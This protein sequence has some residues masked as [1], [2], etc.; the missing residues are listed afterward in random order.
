MLAMEKE[1]II[2]ASALFDEEKLLPTYKIKTGMPGKSYGID[3]ASRLGMN[4]KIIQFAKEY[5]SHRQEKDIDTAINKLEKQILLNEKLTA[6]LESKKRALES[7]EIESNRI[8]NNIDKIKE[9]ALFD[10]EVKK[11]E[12]IQKAREEINQILKNLKDNE[13]KVIREEEQ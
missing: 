10:A 8:L 9:Q 6:E 5:V 12:M 1:N 4:S 13:I 3:V 2:N 7:K 11:E